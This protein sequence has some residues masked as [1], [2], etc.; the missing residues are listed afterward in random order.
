MKITSLDIPTDVASLNA[1]KEELPEAIEVEEIMHGLKAWRNPINHFRVMRLWRGADPAKRTQEWVDKAR[2]GLSSSDWLR[3]YELVWEALNGR[4]VYL[5]EWSPEFHTSKSSLGWN[6]KLVV[7]RG[8]DFG[9]YPATVFCQ[10]FPHNRLMVLREAVGEDIDTERFAYEVDRLSHEW[11]PGATFIEFIDPTGRNRA[12]TDGKSYTNILSAKP[13]RARK[14]ISGA[15]APVQR[16]TAVIDFLKENIRGLPCLF[17][18]PSCTTLLKGFNGGYHYALF[19][20]TL[21]SKP[22]KNF[23]SHIHDSLQ[24]LCSKVRTVSLRLDNKY[25]VIEPRFTS[26]KPPILPPIDYNDYS[27]GNNSNS[28]SNNSNSNNNEDRPNA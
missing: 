19:Q 14:I 12:G 22:E 6:P 5:D 23:F 9:L 10:L 7:G 26:A 15:N 2:A 13:L 11:F 27:D 25:S 18:D 21:K 24:Y 8:W 20:G 16:R 3:E 4:P 17:V 1:I 28:N